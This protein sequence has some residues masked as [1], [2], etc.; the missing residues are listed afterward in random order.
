[1]GQLTYT[2]QEVQDRLDAVG[3]LVRPNLLD[4]AYFVGGGS[5]QGGG[6]FPINQRGVTTYTGIKYTID[7]WG[8]EGGDPTANVALTSSGITINGGTGAANFFRQKTDL[9]LTG[10]VCTW[11]VLTADGV[12]YSKTGT[13]VAS[14]TSAYLATPF[15]NIRINSGGSSPGSTDC[16]ISICAD[17]GKTVSVVAAKLEIGDTQTLAHQENGEWVLNEIPNYQ[18]ELA[19]CQRYCLVADWN[20]GKFTVLYGVTKGTG[21]A[22]L[23]M[24][25]PVTMRTAPTFSGTP[26]I[27]IACNGSSYDT[28]DYS[29]WTYSPGSISFK[30]NSLTSG[31]FPGTNYPVRAH[32]NSGT[33]CVISADL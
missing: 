16:G 30:V 13:V 7:R 5:Q 32:F 21:S 11:A 3:T 25:T 24:P 15:G 1:M 9:F 28:T 33:L 31:S 18:Q 23:T 17:K 19:K 2:T 14:S 8:I 10:K 29:P 26:K 4:N 20:N 6:Q 27:T 12:L 22:E